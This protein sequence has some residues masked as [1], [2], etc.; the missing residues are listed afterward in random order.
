MACVLFAC[1]VGVAHLLH[2]VGTLTQ[3]KMEFRYALTDTGAYGR[4]F[5]PLSCS[6]AKSRGHHALHSKETQIAK[7]VA[8]RQEELRLRL[9]NP[10]AYV[11][12]PP[13]PWTKLVVRCVVVSLTHRCS[14]MRAFP[15]WLPLG[16]FF[17]LWSI[18]VVSPA[19]QMQ[20]QHNPRG[21]GSGGLYF[22]G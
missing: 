22:L 14:F 17:F 21:F 12:K 8:A 9:Q 18:S 19:R 15:C 4:S 5:T 13:V 6:S 16:C 10:E 2:S 1:E 7:S 3:N 11:P 20:Q